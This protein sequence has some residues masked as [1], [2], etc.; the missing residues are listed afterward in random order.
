M[1]NKAKTIISLLVLLLIVGGGYYL[2]RSFFGGMYEPVDKNDTSEIQIEIPSGSSLGKVASILYDNNLIKNGTFFKSRVQ[3]L[4]KE[5]EIKTG[6]FT[7]SR[8]MSADE[9]IGVITSEKSEDV[10]ETTKLVIPEGFER[11]LIA[12]RI[13]EQGLGSKEA[14]L[15]ATASAADYIADFPWLQ[16]LNEGESLEGYLFPATYDIPSGA[17]EVDITKQMLKAFQDRMGEYL[18]RDDFNGLSFTKMITLASIIEREI[19]VDDERPLAASVFY[20]R[21]AQGMRLQSCATVQFILGERKAKLTN[22]ETQIDSPYNTYINEGLPPAPI[23][24]PGMKSIEA[25]IN[26]AQTDY[27][28]FVLTGDDGSHTFTSTYEDHLKAKEN[29]K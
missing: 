26:P 16:K 15:N 5:T 28:F 7:L 11:K 10:V 8:S 18:D 23:A 20:N 24:S 12:E 9:I 1:N 14:F 27:L 4:G 19:K 2:Y 3:K 21:I 25:A 17:T 6:E 13:E 22:E 29:M